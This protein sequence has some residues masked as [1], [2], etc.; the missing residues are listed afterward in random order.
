MHVLIYSI[1]LDE[2]WIVPKYLFQSK[3]NWLYNAWSVMSV[4]MQ[5]FLVFENILNTYNFKPLNPT[6]INLASV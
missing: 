5:S 6:D 3:F 4:G 2:Y 1:R